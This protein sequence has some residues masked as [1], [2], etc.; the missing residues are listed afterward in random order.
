[1]AGEGSNGGGTPVPHVGRVLAERW[2][3]KARIGTGGM[4]SVHAGQDLRLARPIAVKILHHHIAEN[5]DARERLAREA[6]AIAQLKH[7][8]VIEVY[9]YSIEDPDCT[10]LVSELIEGYS[11]RQFLDRN[12]TPPPEVAVMIVAEVVRAL[13]AAHDV[14]VVHRDVKPDNILIGHGQGRPKLSDFGIAKV[15]SE[16]KMTMTGNLVGSP[17]Y[18]SPEQADG[19]AVDH[20]TDLYSTGILLYRMV[21]G[22]LPFRGQTP[23]DT[24]RKVSLGDYVDPMELQPNCPSSIA[25]IIRKALTRE[26]DQRYQTAD[27]MLKDLGQ[28]LQD[29]ALTATWEELPQYF[30]DPSGYFEA[31][32]PQLA[33]ELEARG[34][35]LLDKGEESRAVDCFNRAIALGDGSQNT[36]ELVRQLSNRRNAG[37]VRRVVWAATL[38]VGGIASITGVILVT[39]LLSSSAPPPKAEAAVEPLVEAKVEAPPKPVEAKAAEPKA[40]AVKPPAPEPKAVVAEAAPK[41][42]VKRPAKPPKRRRPRR[43]KRSRPPVESRPA[44]APEPKPE[45]PL[46]GTLHVGTKKWVDVYVD[47][48]KLGR[49]PDRT[50]YPLPPG[51]HRLRAEKPNSNCLPFERTFNIVAGETTRL[52]LKVVCP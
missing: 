23:I 36:F 11:L 25:G 47:G 13:K 15:M 42:E 16:T 10:W 17:S 18:M 40:E 35:A 27:E 22:T 26:I 52:R 28:V 9:D 5:P 32:K 44:P 4:A 46:Y 34:R 29:A 14:G 31:L 39:D 19:Q 24:I 33:R 12:E 41:P 30:A 8:N 21:T 50:Q 7:E 3:V 45:E 51:S 6:R 1:M 2:E 37:R 43:A 20:R 38:A 48:K 49:A